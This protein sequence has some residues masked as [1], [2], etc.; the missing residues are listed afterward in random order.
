MFSESYR[1]CGTASGFGFSLARAGGFSGER[2]YY[3]YFHYYTLGLAAKC[4][5]SYS[6]VVV[7]TTNIYR[8]LEAVV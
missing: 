3:Y 7:P 6:D 8:R 2:D 4:Q 5:W 1:C